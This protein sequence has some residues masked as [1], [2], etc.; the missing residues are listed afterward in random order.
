LTRIQTPSARPVAKLPRS[1]ETR[2]S[3]YVGCV[4]GEVPS[5][6][7]GGVAAPFYTAP[8]DQALAAGNG[9]PLLYVRCLSPSALIA[10]CS[11]HYQSSSVIDC[12]SIL[13]TVVGRSALPQMCLKSKNT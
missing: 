1:P 10:T 8:V 2:N 4:R 7:I 11:C 3:A 13:S 12:Q 5:T 9:L 6:E